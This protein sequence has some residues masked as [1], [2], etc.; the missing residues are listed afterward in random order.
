LFVWS[1]TEALRD[2]QI[3]NKNMEKIIKVQ[4]RKDIVET[5]EGKNYYNDS[6]S[7][8]D[9]GNLNVGSF[10]FG[11]DIDRMWGH[12]YEYDITTE[13]EWKDSV[14]LLL[15]QEHFKTASEFKK[16]IDQKSIPAT[17]SLW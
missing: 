13:K 4:L 15:M 6:V 10:D 17:T 3:T 16:W 1:T 12:D 11:P 14:L 2:Y 8:E 9:N 7:I 5:P